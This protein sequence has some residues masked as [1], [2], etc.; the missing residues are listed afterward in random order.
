MIKFLASLLGRMHKKNT[1]NFWSFIKRH[2]WDNWEY[3]HTY[4]DMFHDTWE[5][6]SNLYECRREELSL[7]SENTQF[8]LQKP[9]PSFYSYE[10][11]PNIKFT[12]WLMD[13]WNTK[14]LYQCSPAQ[15]LQEIINF[16]C[17][18]LFI[19]YPKRKEKFYYS[20]NYVQN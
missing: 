20:K 11:T 7:H 19:L 14:N 18:L 3:M 1:T 9:Q 12:E 8:S 4:L 15:A 5:T 16:V 10:S 17:E 13:S 2:T 6:Y